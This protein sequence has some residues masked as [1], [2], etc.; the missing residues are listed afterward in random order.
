MLEVFNHEYPPY[1][2]TL[3]NE[4]NDSQGIL[5]YLS[6][7]CAINSDRLFAWREH[8]QSGY[9]SNRV[10]LYCR[11][12]AGWSKQL[13][14]RKLEQVNV[15]NIDDNLILCI[16]TPTLL[17][18]LNKIQNN[19][20]SI[21]PF[22]EREAT[23]IVIGKPGSKDS[24]EAV[25]V[26]AYNYTSTIKQNAVAFTMYIE[27]KLT[28]NKAGEYPAINTI[29]NLDQAEWAEVTKYFSGLKLRAI[30]RGFRIANNTDHSVVRVFKE[31]EFNVGNKADNELDAD[32]IQ[33][34]HE[35]LMR[36]VTR[37]L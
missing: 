25:D 24:E 37:R 7:C 27:K 19:V 33:F 2:L 26:P 1:L 32:T 30:D 22:I 3:F 10:R 20:G 6:G 34:L 28:N 13:T 15:N 23:C 12:N 35:M 31:D 14:D 29:S 18:T 11:D 16:N 36:I 17:E 4:S 5:Y 9:N 8:D 21:E